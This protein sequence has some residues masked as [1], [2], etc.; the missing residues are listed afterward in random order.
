MEIEDAVLRKLGNHACIVT[1]HGRDE[2]TGALILETAPNGDVQS[3][4]ISHSDTSLRIR[5]KW[6]L[7][8]AKGIVY[9]HSKHV[10]WADCNPSNLLLTSDL[11]IRLCDFGGSSI[12]GLRPTVCPGA[13]YSLPRLEWLAD[14]NMDIFSVG[15][16]LFEIFTLRP[17]YAGL[18]R[19][20]KFLFWYIGVDNGGAVDEIIANYESAVFPQIPNYVPEAIALVICRCWH[21]KYPSSQALLDDMH[22]AYNT[23]CATDGVPSG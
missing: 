8:L 2:S 10:I 20:W 17:P 15:S 6:G 16:V 7:Q 22:A 1:Y 21:L 23:F 13:A 4:L 18:S 11:D 5:A 3:Y 12:S 9:L 19:E 14:P